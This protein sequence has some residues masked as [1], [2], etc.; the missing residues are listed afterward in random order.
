V[1]QVLDRPH[2]YDLA[3]PDSQG[4]SRDSAEPGQN[5]DGPVMR[6]VSVHRRQSA[7]RYRIG[8][9]GEQPGILLIYPQSVIS[10]YLY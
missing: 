9:S 4:G 1:L 6:H 7:R 3:K 5:G 8:E 2:S 10:E